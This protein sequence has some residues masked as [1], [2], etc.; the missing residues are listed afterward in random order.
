MAEFSL[1]TPSFPCPRATVKVYFY[2]P[3]LTDP[4][5]KKMSFRFENDSL[6]HYVD[7]TI[8]LS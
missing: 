6:I 8:R 2:I 5:E 3:D 7:K 1:P 4:S